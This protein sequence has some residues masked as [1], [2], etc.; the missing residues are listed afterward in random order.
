MKEPIAGRK[1]E[2]A[3]LNGLLNKPRS[4][5]VAVYGRRRIGKTFLIRQVYSNHLVFEC[6][7][8][9]NRS[10]KMQLESFWSALFDLGA[11]DQT[12]PYPNSWLQAFSLLKAYLNQLPTEQKKVVF[13]DEISWFDT[14]R[15]G[16]L[17][18]LDQFWNQ[19]CTKRPD[20]ILVICGSAASWII[21][22]VVND[23]GGLHNRITTHI[24]L[25]PFKLSETKA[26]LEMQGLHLVHRDILLLYMCVGGVPFYLVDLPRGS[27][28]PQILDY[29][30][31]GSGA[32][33][34][35]EFRNLYAALF[36]N[37]MLHEKLVAALAS[38]NRGLTRSEL[39]LTAQV[40][41]GGGISTALEELIACGFVQRIRPIA[42]KQEDAL[43]RLID[44]FSLFHYKFL[45][46]LPEETSWAQ[47]CAQQSWHIWAG[48][49]FESTCIKHVASIKKALGISGMVTNTYSWQ[50]RGDEQQSGTQVDLI[51]DRADA[52]INLVEAKF[53]KAPFEITAAYAD[54]L[55]EKSHIFKTKTKTQKNV[56][57]TLI[58]SSGARKN[59]HYLSVI[60]QEIELEALFDV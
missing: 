42:T 58:S 17:A 30:L 24:A 37:Y 9:N 56:F 38:K 29:L 3:H 41:S 26:F 39:V 57:I 16:F 4:E 8:I 31:L 59:A 12:Q 48:F 25:Q 10:L 46:Q 7:G 2:I 33:L 34:K 11:I 21:Q 60:D 18:A 45:H 54:Q 20:I 19:Y 49:A 43:Y 47:L 51:L 32:R 22:K 53:L 50:I 13:L 6:S 5:F 44:E 27:S 55:R 1:A 36:S 35:N 15:S 14:Q 23:R 52:C 40:E 28:V